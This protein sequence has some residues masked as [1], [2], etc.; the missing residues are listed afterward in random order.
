MGD[1][2]TV[3]TLLSNGANVNWQNSHGESSLMYAAFRGHEAIVA[4]FLQH[5]AT[6]V[7]LQVI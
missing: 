5:A 7:N 3:G 4:T 6:H 1:I 2:E